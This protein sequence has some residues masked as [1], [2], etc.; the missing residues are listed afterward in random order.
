MVHNAKLTE[1]EVLVI[2]QRQLNGE[3]IGIVYSDYKDKITKGGFERI[4][5]ERK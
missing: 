2:K 1:E 3:R 4:W 5:Y